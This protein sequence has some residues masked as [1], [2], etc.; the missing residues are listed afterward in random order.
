M[1]LN[2]N[3]LSQL[4]A[5]KLKLTQAQAR[6]KFG[7]EDMEPQKAELKSKARFGNEEKPEEGSAGYKLKLN[8]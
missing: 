6:A 4:K 5:H 1:K 8:A 7:N 3:D 2:N